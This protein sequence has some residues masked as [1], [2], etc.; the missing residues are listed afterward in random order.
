M[1]V[2][3]DIKIRR[4]AETN[5][6]A[7]GPPVIGTKKKKVTLRIQGLESPPS[8]ERKNSVSRVRQNQNYPSR[9]ASSLAILKMEFF[10]I[11]KSLIVR[12]EDADVN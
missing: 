7:T 12:S 5:E 11:T 8:N 1:K 9:N 2:I 3:S 4:D 6:S 10:L